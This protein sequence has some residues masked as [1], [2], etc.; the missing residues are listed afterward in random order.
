MNQFEELKEMRTTGKTSDRLRPG[1]QTLEST[2]EGEARRETLNPPKVVELLGRDLDPEAVI[3]DVGAGTGM[4]SFPLAAA[5]PEA[6]VHALEVR[7]DAL[8]VLHARVLKEG[9]ANVRPLRM[10]EGTVPALPGGAKAN[11][12]FICDVL[13][14][15]KPADKDAF[16]LSLRSILAPEGRLVVIES[17]E[18]WEAHLVDIQDAGFAQRRIAQI[19]AARRIMAFEAANFTV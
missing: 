16:L 5:F 13:D 14:F 8:Q 12:I 4:F 10:A 7:T 19:V 17:R 11:L 2:L 3:V 6:T 9:R 1:G 18:N 15:V